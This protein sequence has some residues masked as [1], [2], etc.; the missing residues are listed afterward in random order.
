MLLTSA[1]HYLNDNGDNGDENGDRGDGDDDSE[2]S[3]NDGRDEDSDDAETAKQM[4]RKHSDTLR[5]AARNR[6]KGE[7]EL[8]NTFQKE[9][10]RKW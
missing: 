9:G 10:P 1:Y 8:N 7:N 6:L 5:K 3:E 2:G 4:V